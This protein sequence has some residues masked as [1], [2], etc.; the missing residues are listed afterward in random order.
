[1]ENAVTKNYHYISKV[2]NMHGMVCIIVIKA[3]YGLIFLYNINTPT[4]AKI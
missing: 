1:M 3:N 4:M 2:E